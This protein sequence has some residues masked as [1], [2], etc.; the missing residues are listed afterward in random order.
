MEP[1]IEEKEATIAD[2]CRILNKKQLLDFVG[3][4]IAKY[5][6]E[7]SRILEISRRMKKKDLSILIMEKCEENA[8]LLEGL[9]Q[10][11]RKVMYEKLTKKVSYSIFN[12]LS[13]RKVVKKQKNITYMSK[14]PE[15]DDIRKLIGKNPVD[16]RKNKGG[17]ILI[18]SESKE[19]K[20]KYY[21]IN[22]E[23]VLDLERLVYIYYPKVTDINFSFRTSDPMF[24]VEDA[25]TWIIKNFHSTVS[26][27]L[28]AFLHPVGIYYITSSTDFILKFFDEVISNNN[29]LGNTGG[30]NANID[31]VELDFRGTI[32]HRNLRRMYTVGEDVHRDPAIKSLLDEDARIIG[33]DGRMYYRCLACKYTISSRKN[34]S[35]IAVERI[36]RDLTVKQAK[37]L[38][39]RI[40]KEY[41]ERLPPAA[42]GR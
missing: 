6:D 38:L 12:C 23:P 4:K 17:F 3:E 13:G 33:L 22:D 11:V 14:I 37:D 32:S 9:K 34:Q 31:S 40:T 35:Y 29:L 21:Y 1:K 30:F 16:L 26:E 5:E 36:S 10:E 42:F 18:K 27:S 8:S 2:F 25:R 7:S 15:I 39:E 19:V 24:F 20:G 28:Q 41:L